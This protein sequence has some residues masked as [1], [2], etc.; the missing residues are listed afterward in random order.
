MRILAVE[1]I[2]ELEGEL[3]SERAHLED[4][5]GGGEGSEGGV[6]QGGDD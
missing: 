6:T 4:L 2:R 3:A 1:Q 5:R